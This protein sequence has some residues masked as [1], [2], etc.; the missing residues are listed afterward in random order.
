VT[1]IFVFHAYFYFAPLIA[2]IFALAFF[3]RPH[4]KGVKKISG[5]DVKNCEAITETI[6]KNKKNL[7]K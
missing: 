2:Y 1:S 5:T 4:R 7:S 3:S 6:E